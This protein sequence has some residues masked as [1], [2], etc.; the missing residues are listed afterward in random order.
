MILGEMLARNARMYDDEIAL[1][2]MEPALNKRRVMT[3]K[4]FFFTTLL[5]KRNDVKIC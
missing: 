5:P 3:W 4:A 1:I 2:E